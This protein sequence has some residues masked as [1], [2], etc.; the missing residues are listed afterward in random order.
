LQQSI[1][2]FNTG[3][4]AVTVRNRHA[5]LPAAERRALAKPAPRLGAPTSATVRG[6]S[7][8]FKPY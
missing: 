2:F 4:G 7:A 8:N 6:G 1:A 5:A 3:D